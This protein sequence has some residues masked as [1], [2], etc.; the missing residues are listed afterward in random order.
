MSLFVTIIHVTVCTFMIL[1]ILLQQ[2]KSG[3]GA[4]GGGSGGASF[5]TSSQP[6]ILSKLTV[7]AS[8]IFMLTSMTLAWLSTRDTSVVADEPTI[9]ET[10][11]VDDENGEAADEDGA[12][13]DDDVARDD[14]TADLDGAEAEEGEGA[15]DESETETDE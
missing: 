4:I 7:G 9:E 2:G 13:E 11:A 3:M 8:I 5:G 10:T 15:G 6:N 12:A 14:G 1:V